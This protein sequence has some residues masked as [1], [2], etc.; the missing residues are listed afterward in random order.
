V[1]G[2]LRRQYLLGLVS[3]KGSFFKA[4]NIDLLQA[5][6]VFAS[7]LTPQVYLTECCIQHAVNGFSEAYRLFGTFYEYVIESEQM[8]VIDLKSQ[9]HHFTAVWWYLWF[10]SSELPLRT[11]ALHGVSI[12]L[13]RDRV[14]KKQSGNEN[15]E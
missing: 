3:Q 4:H 15:H 14:R 12:F 1:T 8:Q 7:T 2:L 5:S 9:L 6:I 13:C 10:A 11:V